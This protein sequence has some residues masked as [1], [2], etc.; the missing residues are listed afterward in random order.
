MLKMSIPQGY[1]YGCLWMSRMSRV[2]GFLGVS[3]CL[4]VSKR[5]YGCLCVAKVVYGYPWVS[6]EIYG[7]SGACVCMGSWRRVFLSIYGCLWVFISVYGV[8]MG[9][10]GFLRVPIVFYEFLDYYGCLWVFVGVMGVYGSF[11]PRKSRFKNPR[12]SRCITV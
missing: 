5:V 1:L 8:C 6:T 7:F 3:G 11:S 2:C 10:Y 9:V 4:C 12:Q